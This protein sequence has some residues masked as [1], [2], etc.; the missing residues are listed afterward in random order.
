MKKV[1]FILLYYRG[2]KCA[3]NKHWQPFSDG[4]ED[5]NNGIQ[6]YVP[7]S[8][9]FFSLRDLGCSLMGKI[10]M[11]PQLT[12]SRVVDSKLKFKTVRIVTQL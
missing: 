4:E 6:S 12:F 9:Y 5:G 2:L 11:T 10:I 1:N 7:V 3:T 8:D